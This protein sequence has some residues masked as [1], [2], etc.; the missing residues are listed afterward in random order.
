MK[1]CS[2]KVLTTLHEYS[3]LSA[4]THACYCY[5]HTFGVAYTG[6]A[7]MST[8]EVEKRSSHDPFPIFSLWFHCQADC[9]TIMRLIGRINIYTVYT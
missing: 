2:S 9:I 6:V 4:C 3:K 7:L 5:H 1:N 8:E